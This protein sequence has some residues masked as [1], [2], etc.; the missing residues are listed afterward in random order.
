MASD[1]RG[2]KG[3]TPKYTLPLALARPD[4]A[5]DM[6]LRVESMCI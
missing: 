2:G 6:V 4:S 1:V 3:V 5:Y